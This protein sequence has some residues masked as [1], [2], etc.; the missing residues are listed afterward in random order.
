MKATNY[1]YLNF[2]IWIIRQSKKISFPIKDFISTVWVYL[3]LSTTLLKYSLIKYERAVCTAR[4]GDKVLQHKVK[5]R[6]EPKNRLF[7][8]PLSINNT[9]RSIGLPVKLTTNY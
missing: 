9:G 4:V 1:K 5:Q 7:Q 2:H 8:Q 3:S 6:T